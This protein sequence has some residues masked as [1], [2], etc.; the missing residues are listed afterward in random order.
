[1]S[2]KV[3]LVMSRDGDDIVITASSLLQFLSDIECSEAYEM[4]SR[5]VGNYQNYCDGFG[6]EEGLKMKIKEGE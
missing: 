2:R 6:V 5:V 1:M 3:I 4:V